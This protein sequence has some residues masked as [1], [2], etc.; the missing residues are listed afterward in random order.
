MIL[1]DV[2]GRIW[3]DRQ[4]SG[5]DGKRMV[6]VRDEAGARL[7]AVDLIDVTTGDVVLIATDEAAVQV[8]GAPIDAVV[9]ARVAGMDPTVDGDDAS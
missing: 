8:G 1:A 9:V 2:V 5:L 6:V 3:S 7:V 4:L